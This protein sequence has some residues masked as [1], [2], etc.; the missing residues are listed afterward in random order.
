MCL[1]E[2]FVCDGLIGLLSIEVFLQ[3]MALLLQVAIVLSG[4]DVPRLRSVDA[5]LQSVAEHGF[6]VSVL[7]GFE[8]SAGHDIVGTQPG[9]IGRLLPIVLLDLLFLFSAYAR[10]SNNGD[11][12][13]VDMRRLFVFDI[14]SIEIFVVCLPIKQKNGG[15]SVCQ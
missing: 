5:S 12:G 13:G 15:L 2:R 14:V 3:L 10:L 1:S 4:G 7:V 9:R 8:L 11:E 6:G